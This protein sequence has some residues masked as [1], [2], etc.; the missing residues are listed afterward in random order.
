M[1]V[2]ALGTGGALLAVGFGLGRLAGRSRA[3]AVAAGA[4][5]R[6]ALGA[7]LAVF[8]ALVVTGLDHRVE[9]ALVAAMPDWLASAASS[10]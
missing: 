6:F 4:R 1:F 2:Y 9:T 10:L 5:G 3:A 7:T 8:G